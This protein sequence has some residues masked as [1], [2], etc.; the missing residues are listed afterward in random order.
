M[1][2]RKQ[3]IIEAANLYYKEDRT[4]SDIAKKINVSRPTVSNL[5]KEGREL[6]IVNITIREIGE[7]N[8]KDQEII[9]NKFDLETVLI[10]NVKE[11]A[12]EAVGGLGAQYV[13][14][15]LNDINTLGIGWGTTMSSFVQAVNILHHPHLTIIPMIG[16]VSAS[17]IS[18]HSNHLAFTLAQKFDAESRMFY[19]PAVADTVSMKNN[20]EKSQ[21]VQEG[22]NNA[23]NVD[24]A[25]LAVG[26]PQVSNTYRNLGYL[27]KKKENEFTEAEVT[28][29][30]LASFYDEK[31]NHV[32]TSLSE[33]MIGPTIPDIRN[34]KEV[35]V[36]SA[37]HEKANSIYTLLKNEIIDHL[38]IDKS[39][40]EVLIDKKK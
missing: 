2:D 38:I 34:M 37:G 12:K 3:L 15:R 27:N 4:Q 22:L 19:A 31:G 29:D 13:E 7:S 8:Y 11:N 25:V 21:I 30:I 26:N 40:S 33:R 35:V 17:D 5:L 24:L 32:P 36:I 28:G 18:F 14:N 39:I 20:F 10:T 16:G 9:K 23:K 1:Y 6:G